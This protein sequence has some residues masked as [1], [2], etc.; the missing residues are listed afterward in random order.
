MKNITRRKT[1]VYISI[2]FFLTASLLVFSTAKAEHPLNGLEGEAF[3]DPSKQI[4]MP[5]EW[6]KKPVIY[7]KDNQGADLVISFNQQIYHTFLPLINDYAK[8]YGLNIKI[9]EGTCGNS[10]GVLSNKSA[11]M[12]MFCC[13]PGENDRLPGLIFHTMGVTPIALLVHPDN[14]IE[15]VT[16]KQAQDIFSGEI[17]KWSELRDAS[18]QPGPNLLVRPVG[19]LHCKKRPG[20][21]KLLLDNIDLFSPR[22]SEVGAI[23]DMIAVLFSDQ[24][25]IGYETLW[26]AHYKYKQR[27]KV[28]ALKIDGLAPD[29][30][31]HLISGKYPLYRVFSIT[32]WGG[33]G[34]ANPHAQKLVDYLL[35]KIE[36]LESKL[37]IIPASRLRKAGWKFKGNELVGKPG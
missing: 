4:Q 12:A 9:S 17:H 3:S 20:H 10:A 21:W 11:D 31:E 30:L 16:F 32:I 18:G 8:K 13:P 29:E 26:M 35:E 6:I 19:R 28:K 24:S 33:K 2:S 1:L 22:L 34:L 23:P 5:E 14:P 36:Q 7:D 27:G 25:A 15:N 37:G